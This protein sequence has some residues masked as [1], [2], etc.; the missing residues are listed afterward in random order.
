MNEFS[1]KTFILF[2]QFSKHEQLY[3]L[4]KNLRQKIKPKINIKRKKN[5]KR[6]EK[7]KRNA[8]KKNEKRKRNRKTK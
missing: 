8:K 7:E 2:E 4:K 1:I 5:K 3:Y 6:K